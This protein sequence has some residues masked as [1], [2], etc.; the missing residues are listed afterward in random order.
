MGA[1][2]SVAKTDIFQE[3][4]TT[5]YTNIENECVTAT[6]QNISDVNIVLD[7]VNLNGLTFSQGAS[8]NSQCAFNNNID[9][10][11]G[12]IQDV[13]AENSAQNREPLIIPIVPLG[14][15]NQWSETTAVSIIS[16]DIRNA[17]QNSCKTTSDQMIENINIAI[18]NSD[19]GDIT[20]DQQ[21]NL[22]TSCLVDNLVIIQSSIQQQIDSQN[23]AGGQKRNLFMIIGGFILLILLVVFVIAII[24]IIT[25]S[26]SKKNK[27]ENEE[28]TAIPD[29]CI[30]LEGV[31]MINCL[32]NF[33]PPKNPYCNTSLP[34]PTKPTSAPQRTV[35]V[36]E[37]EE[38]DF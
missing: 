4:K 34:P 7:G 1:A 15:S 2:N 33:P 25:R 27:D 28:C 10:T 18:Y 31:N 38:V 8:V 16:Q 22:Q 20:F 21:A 30:G 36:E 32:K 13:I 24:G 26:K 37:A 14:I 19:V 35:P 12:I 6:F 9:I 11:A 17:I 29:K 3:A 5:Y 23:N